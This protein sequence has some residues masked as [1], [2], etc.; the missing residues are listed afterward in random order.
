[1]AD[2]ISSLQ[3]STWK[4][5]IS[6]LL[7]YV[8]QS[9]TPLCPHPKWAEQCR[10]PESLKTKRRIW[11][12]S[13]HDYDGKLSDLEEVRR[14]KRVSLKGV[15]RLDLYGFSLIFLLFLLWS[16]SLTTSDKRPSLDV[17][18]GMFS[19]RLSVAKQKQKRFLVLLLKFAGLNDSRQ[20]ECPAARMMPGNI[21]DDRYTTVYNYM[22][23][24]PHRNDR[25]NVS[26][27]EQMVW[28]S[29]I[30]RVGWDVEYL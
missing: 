1:M 19:N 30:L 16:F 20:G 23:S 2:H 7:R 17:L 27:A 18:K 26:S 6:V 21:L 28:S 10:L 12:N 9:V 3:A 25:L 11:K 5:L 14:E 4:W 8:W 13:A 24:L 29:K 22:P 15:F